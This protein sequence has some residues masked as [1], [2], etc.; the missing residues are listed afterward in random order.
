MLQGVALKRQKKK[1]KKKKK[2]KEATAA[3]PAARVCKPLGTG[4]R[5][6]HCSL[7]YPGQSSWKRWLESRVLVGHCLFPQKRG[8]ELTSVCPTV[9]WDPGLVPRL[10][11]LNL[12]AGNVH[13]AAD[14][15]S[16]SCVSTN[17]FNPHANTAGACS[18]CS[19][20]NVSCL[21]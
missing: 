10:S 12:K 20:V 17:P 4:Q 8:S 2:K 5:W 1:K 14:T 19:P 6:C 18:S 21:A 9:Y 15:A 11:K 16:S 7:A 3:A 13:R